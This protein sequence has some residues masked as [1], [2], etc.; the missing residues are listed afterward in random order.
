MT[1][2]AA[3]QRARPIGLI[4]LGIAVLCFSLGS[5]MVKKAGLPGPT[6]AFWRMLVTSSLWWIILWVTERRIIGLDDI[7]RT[8][9]P[10]IA[11]GL[12]LTCFFTGVSK[13]SVANAEFVA[14]LTPLIVVPAGAY[15]F[16]E[17]INLKALW[18]GVLSL[19]G[20][21][22][23]LFNTP[24]RGE[25][26]WAGNIIVF[27][28]VFLWAV[29]L[30]TSRPLRNQMS[31]Q[32]IMASVMTIATA[33]IFPITLVR[34]ELDD[35]TAHSIPYILIL[36]VLT[37]TIAHGLIVVAQRTVPVGTIAILQVAQPALAVGWAYLL[38]DQAILPIQVV[39][40]VLV[41]TGLL[42]VVLIT[43]RSAS[44]SEVLLEPI[45]PAAIVD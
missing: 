20:L 45:G 23:V 17:H 21:M 8:L 41:I 32:S 3:V 11:F 36:S 15:F 38:L 19:V 14:S 2:P 13:T 9:V 30:L 35:V 34:G 33:T 26:T 43:R 16:K 7:K 31:V 10:G 5:T 44:K 1:A 40:M 42:A 39:G 22:L 12:N 25:A 24:P 4:A 28:A 27:G 6:L 29:Y 37:G 18:F